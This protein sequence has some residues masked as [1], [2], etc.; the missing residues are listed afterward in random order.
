MPRYSNF[1]NT[2]ARDDGVLNKETVVYATINDLP[3]TDVFTGTKAYV[4]STNKLYIF[5]NGG[6]NQIA[7][8]NTN[9]SVSFDSS[10]YIMDS[11]SGT[12]TVL[13]LT[14]SDPEGIPLTYSYSFSPSNIV[15]SA[16][17]YSVD[18]SVLTLT[19]TSSSGSYNFKVFGSV[20]D[21]VYT[22]SDSADVSLILQTMTLSSTASSVNEGDSFTVNISS[23]GFSDGTVVGY[24]ITGVSASDINQSLTGGIILNSNGLGTLPITVLSDYTT[25]GSEN[26]VLQLEEPYNTLAG[27]NVQVSINDTS[28]TPTVQVN[29]SATS[30]NEGGSFYFT[31]A[32]TNLPNGTRA[33]YRITNVSQSDISSPSLSGSY[34]TEEGYITI[35]NNAATSPTYVAAADGLT[36][37]NEI[38]Y[39]RLTRFTDGSNNL[40]EYNTSNNF[41]TINDTSITHPSGSVTYT[42]SISQL[43][44]STYT[45]P[46]NVT[47]V[48]IFA[49]GSGGQAGGPVSY[50]SYGA[51]GGGGGGTAYSRF[52]VSP[53]NVL[54]IQRGY[55]AYNVP[56]STG[57]NGGSG[58]NSEVRWSSS[59]GSLLL[60]A[61]GGSGGQSG[62]SSSNNNGGAG[63]YGYVYGGTTPQGTSRGGTGGRGWSTTWNAQWSS[64]YSYPGGG[65]GGAGGYGYNTSN[66]QG[67][68]NGGTSY[69]GNSSGA[70]GSDGGGG[71]GA[72]SLYVGNGGGGVGINGRGASGGIS[73][74]AS[75][76]ATE[77]SNGK[78]GSGGANGTQNGWGGSGWGDYGGG[79]GAAGQRTTDTAQSGESRN[80]G[81]VVIKYDNPSTA[82]TWAFPN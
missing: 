10:S 15:D 68:G 11:A 75:A 77:S 31:L 61:G 26:F 59:G 36:E 34:Q 13:T 74:A 4:Q 16:I 7:L 43:T 62:S 37:G 53:G 14:A 40:I 56:Y 76:W 38:F 32:T 72:A 22:T 9:P 12:P 66:V 52:T 57:T 63:G 78:G 65:G 20:S 30:V 33:Y 24:T 27:N 18:S 73:T 70:A 8:I 41:I 49:V 2:Q 80:G 39:W 47:N 81:I 54:W 44:T 79:Q 48:S 17:D 82:S 67:G 23:T 42:Y 50:A 25:E 71:G 55:C 35:N 46:A 3:L 60:S 19:T 28:L 1:K 45:I 69:G 51:G 64:I 21:G 58:P 5:N 29:R 6:W